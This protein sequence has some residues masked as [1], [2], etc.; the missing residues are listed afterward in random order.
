LT[1]PYLVWTFDY[2]HDSAGQKTMHRLAHELNL[3]GQHAFVAYE[4]RNPAWQTPYHPAPLPGDWIAV[5]PEIIK[6]NPWRAPRVARWVLNNPGKLGGD[7]VY[8]P[9]EMVFVFAELFNDIGV[10]PERILYLPTI[11]LDLYADRH[12]SRAGEVFYVGK[13]QQTRDLPGALEIT[14]DLKRDQRLLADTLNHARVL[15]SFDNV[16][17]MARIALLCGCPVVMIPDGVTQPDLIAGPGIGW[18]EMPQPFDS[19]VIRAQELAAYETFRE[20]LAYFI[21]ITQA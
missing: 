6:G 13:G 21:R 8:D 18:D 19:G 14:N 1:R 5:Y 15:Y 11:E 3:A 4:K 17:A 9:L 16:T 7:K 12:E 2:Y 20:R 10:S